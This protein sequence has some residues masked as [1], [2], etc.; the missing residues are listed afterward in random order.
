MA[1]NRHRGAPSLDELVAQHAHPEQVG[2]PR[3]HVP[4]RLER[5]EAPRAVRRWNQALGQQP[6][7]AAQIR[8]GA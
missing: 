7:N 8:T 1:R 3:V 5:Y 4:P 2:A 6:T